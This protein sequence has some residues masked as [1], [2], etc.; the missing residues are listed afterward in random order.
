MTDLLQASFGDFCSSAIPHM[1]GPNFETYL[2]RLIKPAC[3]IFRLFC[4]NRS[5][6]QQ[7]VGKLI[8]DWAILQHDANTLDQE[9][10]AKM[11]IE[12]KTTAVDF[13]AKTAPYRHPFFSWVVEQTVHL[14]THHLMLGPELELFS[15]RELPVVYWYLDFLLEVHPASIHIHTYMYYH[16]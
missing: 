12:N 6:Q 1:S 11:A 3:M 8:S 15:A 4:E 14:L 13:S 2:Q 16:L 9:A 5:R 10:A 7:R